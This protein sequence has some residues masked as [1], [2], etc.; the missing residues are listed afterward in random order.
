MPSPVSKQQ[1]S[2]KQHGAS[3][4]DS[5]TANVVSDQ[6][7]LLAFY[8]RRVGESQFSISSV[9]VRVRACACARVCM[10]AHVHLRFAHKCTRTEAHTSVHKHICTAQAA[11]HLMRQPLALCAP[12]PCARE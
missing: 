12:P 8:K 7:E 9:C 4:G 2:S 3:G 10:C 6:A 5:K 1:S 11:L